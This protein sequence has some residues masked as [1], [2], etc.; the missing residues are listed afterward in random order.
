MPLDASTPIQY[1][2]TL[3]DAETG[4]RLARANSWRHFLHQDV[5]V[6]PVR[7]GKLRGKFFIP[8]GAPNT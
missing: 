2:F 7:E 6:T 3:I 1:Q 8:K 5:T 4:S